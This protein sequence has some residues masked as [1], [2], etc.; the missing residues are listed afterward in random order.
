VRGD[1]RDREILAALEVDGI[2]EILAILVGQSA[3]AVRYRLAKMRKLGWVVVTRSGSGAPV[4][5][6]RV[7]PKQLELKGTSP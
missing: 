7:D 5:R 3:S 4:W 6:S 2:V 1:A